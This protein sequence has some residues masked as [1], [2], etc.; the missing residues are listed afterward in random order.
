MAND[1]LPGSLT[2]HELSESG[3][4]EAQ[5]SAIRRWY[6][7]AKGGSSAMA[8]AKLHAAAAGEGLRQGGE[9]LLVGGML[10][11]AH[12]QL[13]T[14]LDVKKV[15]IDAVVGVLGLLGGAAMAHEQYGSDLRN[16]GAAGLAVF[17]FRKTYALLAEKKKKAG[18]TPGGTFTGEDFNDQGNFNS[19][20]GAED[21][22]IAAA[23]F[24]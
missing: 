23:R 12:V 7:N 14:G 16:A 2:V 10:G 18:G 3:M 9:S 21:P 24:L 1:T 5:K 22:I 20:I 4:P 6:E 13:K 8:R 19:D 17:S 11:A 15:P